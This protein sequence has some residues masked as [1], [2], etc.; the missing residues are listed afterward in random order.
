M[1]LLAMYWKEIILMTLFGSTV[2]GIA[3][4]ALAKG[5]DSGRFDS[6][7]TRIFIREKRFG[8]K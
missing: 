1:E 3:L 6:E 4:F 2:S 7:E 5:V 8:E